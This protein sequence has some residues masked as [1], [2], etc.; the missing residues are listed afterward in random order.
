VKKKPPVRRRPERAQVRHAHRRVDPFGRLAFALGDYLESIGW[1][2][3]LVGSPRVQQQP[4]E[5]EFNYEFVVR[6]TGGKKKPEA[7]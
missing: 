6:F 2:A 1:S 3:V 4:G 5:R 7:R